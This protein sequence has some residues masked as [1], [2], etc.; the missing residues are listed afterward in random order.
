MI[1]DPMVVELLDLRE[2]VLWCISHGFTDMRFEGDAKVVIDKI[3]GADTSDSRMGAILEE[4]VQF[5]AS[6]PGFSVR[7]VG[8]HSNRVAHL[9]ARKALFLYPT[10]SRLFDFQ[11]W[12]NSRM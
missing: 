11:S 9:V 7:F 4:I 6:S 10:T 2:A 3:L 5:V 1:D 12:L 8:R